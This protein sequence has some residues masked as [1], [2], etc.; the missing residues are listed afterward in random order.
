MTLEFVH[1]L[2]FKINERRVISYVI[3]NRTLTSG[4]SKLQ[5][6]QNIHEDDEISYKKLK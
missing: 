3:Q 1:G 6:H 4:E 2:T 5:N